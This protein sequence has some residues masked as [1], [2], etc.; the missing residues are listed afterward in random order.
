MTL[1]KITLPHPA[2]AGEEGQGK[3]A[4]RIAA[5]FLLMLAL[6]LFARGMAGA[7]Q[8]TVT[9]QTP[10]AAAVTETLTLSGT[11]E[12]QSVEVLTLPD[13]LTVQ[14]VLVTEGQTVQEGEALLRLDAD[15]IAQALTQAQGELDKLNLQLAAYQEE[16]T[17]DDSALT[18]AQTAYDRAKED[19]ASAASTQATQVSRAKAAVSEAKA[20]L[21]DAKSDLN[22]LKSRRSALNTTITQEK[23]A[24]ADLETQL[25]EAEQT[26]QADETASGVTPEA[27]AVSAE[28]EQ[29]QAQIE[30]LE[31]QLTADEE[32]LTSYDDQI[33][34][35]QEAVESA[36]QT[37]DAAEEALEDANTAASDSS[38]SSQRALEDAQTAL[39]EAQDSLADAQADAETQNLQNQA[40]AQILSVTIAQQEA[41]V[42]ALTA[43]QEGGGVLTAP[44]AGKIVSLSGAAG[45]SSGQVEIQ[46]T[47]EGDSYVLTLTGSELTEV[48]DGATLQ[49]VQGDKEAS[50]SI[51]ALVQDGSTGTLTATA[52]LT[53]DWTDGDADVTVTLSSDRYDLT[54][55]IGAYHE[56]NSGGFVYVVEEVESVLGLRY[57]IRRES[58]TLL[59]SNGELA[60]VD[61][62]LSNDSVVVVSASR[63]VEDGEYVRVSE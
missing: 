39:S 36:Q 50:A 22:T 53:G 12:S 33:T 46:L 6:T 14:S 35:A 21:N 40:E 18:S 28:A 24:L 43:L 23:E 2:K 49:V 31:A 63:S 45:G 1:K 4:W 16:Q 30:A 51:A 56:D 7:A 52:Y 11:V 42:A 60:A 13:G 3:A 59:A 29:L 25:A 38:R 5:F 8:T 27:E 9:T 54:I 44:F 34:A 20:A 48:P 61:G 15:T 17:A 55:P 26:A 47:A 58:V 32:A 19:A 41:E 10:K 37:V 62:I 57:Q